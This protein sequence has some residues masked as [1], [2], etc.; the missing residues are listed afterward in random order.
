MGQLINPEAAEYVFSLLK[1]FGSQLSSRH[2]PIIGVVSALVAATAVF[3]ELQASLNTVWEVS[4]QERGGLLNMIRTRLKA[5]VLV[6]G[7]GIVLLA[8]VV[9]GAVLSMLNALFAKALP[10]P[11]GL[12]DHM[13]P[14]IQ[15]G[16]LPLLLA[17]TYKLV[18][19]A[20]I[21]WKDVLVGSVVTALLFLLGKSLFGMYLRLSVL[22]SVYGAAG[23]LVIVLA[24]VYYSSQ[25]FFL[26]AEMCKVFA[27]RYG[28]LSL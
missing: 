9:A 17:S 15:F 18:P 14:V 13:E 20:E 7:I 16:M 1:D 28:S 23:S 10:I 5:F 3:A 21:A 19:D 22:S 26:G 4:P 8:S 12:V 25:V 11:P 6:V 24:W 27:R 2:L